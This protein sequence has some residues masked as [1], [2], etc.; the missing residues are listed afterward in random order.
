MFDCAKQEGKD[1]GRAGSEGICPSQP[2]HGDL[3]AGLAG[4]SGLVDLELLI[5]ELVC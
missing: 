5:I 1:G 2:L 3:A 4:P